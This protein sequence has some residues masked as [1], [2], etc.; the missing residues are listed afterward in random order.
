MKLPDTQTYLG[1]TSYL[2]DRWELTLTGK[3]QR[4]VWERTLKHV[5]N[6]HELTHNR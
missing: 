3:C 6:R 4:T 5:Q 2:A 1:R